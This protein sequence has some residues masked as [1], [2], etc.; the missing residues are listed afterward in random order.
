MVSPNREGEERRNKLGDNLIKFQ[1]EIDSKK[2]GREDFLAR[3]REERE[4]IAEE[5]KRCKE[6][7]MRKKI[8]KHLKDTVRL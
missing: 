6:A 3:D 4:R 2:H 7:E 1:L 5:E 8:S